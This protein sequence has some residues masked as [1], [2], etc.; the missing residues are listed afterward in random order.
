MNGNDGTRAGRSPALRHVLTDMAGTQHM[1]QKPKGKGGSSMNDETTN[2][3]QGA[4]SGV[5]TNG[6]DRTE[7]GE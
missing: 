6:H 4:P 2:T 3:T 7:R 1:Q 5:L